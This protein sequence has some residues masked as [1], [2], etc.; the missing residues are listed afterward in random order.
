MALPLLL[1]L[2][3]AVR[4]RDRREL[5]G[6][7]AIAVLFISSSSWHAHCTHHKVLIPG[8]ADTARLGQRFAQ[9]IR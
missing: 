8:I 4:S 2:Q 1:L 3:P 5:L 7:G 9:Q 6:T